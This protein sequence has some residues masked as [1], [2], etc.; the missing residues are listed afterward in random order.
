MPAF[1]ADYFGDAKVGSIYGLMLT[2]WGAASVF[3]PM[4]T[5]TLHDSS[6]N[7]RSGAHHRSPDGRFDAVAFARASASDAQSATSRVGVAGTRSLVPTGFHPRRD[8]RF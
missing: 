1:V 6:G 5:A 7:Y 8:S 2:D 4:L 3:G